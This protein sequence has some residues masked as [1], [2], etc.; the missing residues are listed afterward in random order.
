MGRAEAERLANF[1]KYAEDDEEEEDMRRI[2]VA[3]DMP[4]H[5]YAHLL[6][7]FPAF[8]TGRQLPRFAFQAKAG[9]RGKSPRKRGAD[10]DVDLEA[11]AEELVGAERETLR[12]GTGT[13]WV[14][15][16]MRSPGWK[17]SWW[18]RILLWWHRVFC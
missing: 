8:V 2:W 9:K 17:S 14:G 4:N 3:P 13:I 1:G 5:E 6:G 11:G 12:H 16:R 10:M 15:E 18:Q 7:A